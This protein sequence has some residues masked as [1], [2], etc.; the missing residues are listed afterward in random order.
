MNNERMSVSGIL[1]LNTIVLYES[2][3]SPGQLFTLYKLKLYHMV[4]QRLLKPLLFSLDAEKAHHLTLKSLLA[5]M[6]IPGVKALLYSRYGVEDSRLE[7]NLWGIRFKNPVGLAAGLDKDGLI[8]SDW[9]YLGFGFVEVGTVTPRPQSGN[10]PKR[11]F[12][13]PKDQALIN[14]M[15]FNNAGVD[16]LAE[17]L[18][19][20]SREGIVMGANIGKNKDTPN[21][22]AVEDY[23]I[24]FDKLKSYVDYFVVNVSSPNTPGLRELQQKEPLRLLLSRLQEQNH[25]QQRPHPILLKIAP[26]LTRVQ[27]ND[28]AEVVQQTEMTGVVAT[29]T[30]L[31][32]EGL[33]TSTDEVNTIGNGGL[34]GNPLTQHATDI[35]KILKSQLD[36][37]KSVVGV[38]GIMADTDAWD[39]LENGAD[40]IQVYTGFVYK[41]PQLVQDILRLVLQKRELVLNSI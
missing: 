23:L 29:N 20:Q 16:K 14:R 34:S 12:R 15:G 37:N 32:R 26:D 5:L 6:H 40:L 25:K 4:Y 3:G 2:S 27:L 30:T 1:Y 33:M 10:P 18:H 19:K 8:G 13:L 41:G 36:S 35:L 31:S 22:Q 39:R 24:C 28:I 38:G 9:K 11:L 7:Q 17:R 21:E